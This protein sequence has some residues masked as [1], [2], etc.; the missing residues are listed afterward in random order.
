MTSEDNK[1]EVAAERL[2][3]GEAI[4]IQTNYRLVQLRETR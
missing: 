4:P 2:A 1:L 3:D